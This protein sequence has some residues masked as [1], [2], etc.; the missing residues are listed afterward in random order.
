MASPRPE[1]GFTLIEVS[2]AIVIGLT[3]L[4]GAVAIYN[5]A[6]ESVATG[7]MKE[8]VMTLGT[9]VEEIT[10]QTGGN[11]DPYN[12]TNRL[13][14]KFMKARPDDY[15]RSP[16]GGTVGTAAQ[17]N[18]IGGWWMQPSDTMPV[19]GNEDTVAADGAQ[20]IRGGLQYFALGV[21]GTTLT[22]NATGSFWDKA[23]KRQVI[24]KGWVV[25]GV[26]QK[27]LDGWCVWGPKP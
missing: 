2:L 24:Y 5:Q 18:G 25:S 7:Q 17:A 1:R 4:G 22:P 10:A 13:A 14:T 27:N 20:D 26:N 21:G 3:I 6:R 23:S 11:P 8:K 9:V 15:N 16:W 19:I 12:D